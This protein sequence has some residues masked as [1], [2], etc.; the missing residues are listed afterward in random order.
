MSYYYYL[1]I[2]KSSIDTWAKIDQQ[3]KTNSWKCSRNLRA[4]S[5]SFQLKHKVSYKYC[6]PCKRYLLKKSFRAHLKTHSSTSANNP[7]ST[8]GLN[9]SGAVPQTSADSDSEQETS[10]KEE[11]EEEEEEP[12]QPPEQT[13]EQDPKINVSS[14]RSGGSSSTRKKGRKSVADWNSLGGLQKPTQRLHMLQ[15]LDRLRKLDK[16]NWTERK[17]YTITCQLK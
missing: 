17:Q 10:K 15:T 12:E 4:L 2:G 5:L 16:L 14:T 3:N 8:P 13:L 1:N 9:A 7:S 6:G 11:A